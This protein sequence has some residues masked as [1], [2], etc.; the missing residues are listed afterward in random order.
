MALCYQWYENW[1]IEVK[2]DQ[3][4]TKHMFDPPYTVQ[5][6]AYNMLLVFINTLAYQTLYIIHLATYKKGLKL[7]STRS[8]SEVATL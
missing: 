5:H 1:L 6:V 2:I 8:G 7:M 4:M 3:V